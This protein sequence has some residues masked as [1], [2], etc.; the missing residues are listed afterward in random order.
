MKKIVSIVTIA[1]ALFIVSCKTKKASTETSTS[2]CVTTPTYTADIKPIIDASCG[3]TCHSAQKRKAG[4]DLS[5][6]ESVKENAAQ[7]RFLGAIKHEQGFDPMPAY[8]AKLDDATIQKI[9]CWIK[10]GMPQ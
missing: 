3:T 2:A 8:A 5:T 6:Y 1:L 4:I 9:E 7:K 10:G